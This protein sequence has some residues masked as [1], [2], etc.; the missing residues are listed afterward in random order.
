M[1]EMMRRDIPASLAFQNERSRNGTWAF[2]SQDLTDIDSVHF[3][4][5]H[6]FRAKGDP[7]QHNSATQAPA[8]LADTCT[9]NTAAGV[10]CQGFFASN[11]N[12]ANMYTVA[13]KRKLSENFTWYITAAATVNG[14]SAHFDL[15]AGGRAVTTDCHDATGSSGG[16]F[17]NPHCWT[18]TTLLGVS[19]GAKWTF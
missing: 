19:S 13:W 4:W 5:A 17:A 6:A 3:G 10:A 2:V 12:S 8:S 16:A 7:G 11:D 18:G 9:D 1:Y 14:P 15:G